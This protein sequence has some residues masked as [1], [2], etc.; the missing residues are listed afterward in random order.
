MNGRR[1][2]T[3]LGGGCLICCLAGL[4][5]YG[6]GGIRSA[7]GEKTLTVGLFSDSYWEVQ[8]GYAYRMLE[9]AEKAFQ[10]QY[11]Q[12]QVEFTSG[13]MK[14][15]YSEWLAEQVLSGKAPDVFIILGEDFNDYA[16]TGVLKDLSSFIEKDDS[17]DLEAYYSSAL[18]AGQYHQIQYALP[19]ECAPKLMFVNKTILDQEGIEMPDNQWNWEEFY[20]ICKKTTR[21]TDGN[22]TIDQFGV[23]GYTW[24]EAFESNGVRV[25]NEE[26]TECSL[27]GSGA[28]EAVNFLERL[29]GLT[30]EYIATERDFDL[31]NVVFQPMLF[32]E[33]RAYQSYPLSVKKYSGF[34]W[35]CIPMP[36]GPEGEN[37]STLDTLLLAMNERTAMEEEAW[38][39]MKTMT[40]DPKIQKK[41][42]TYSEGVSVLRQVTEADETLEELMEDAGNTES[43]NLHILSNAVENAAQAP[44]F[45]NAQEA[46]QEVNRAVEA[47]MEGST[48]ISSELIIWN[49]Q[50][51]QYLAEQQSL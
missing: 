39:F 16:R 43:L 29:K 24:E 40:A 36:A 13:I 42:F 23:V 14:A 33:F 19:Y 1:K 18:S 27:T 9:E 45:R 25:F 35:G 44:R 6:S 41:I 49:R 28:E 46:V 37:I 3:I 5:I 38:A 34:E 2:N 4:L 26:G 21:D 17:F 10:K 7:G 48:N 8:N 31:G 30:G 11:P 15:D 22:G 20:Q 51:N 50:I 47:I 12:V 32:S